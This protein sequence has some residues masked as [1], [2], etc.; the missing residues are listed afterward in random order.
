MAWFFLLNI[1]TLV[2]CIV[3]AV[4]TKSDIDLW[5]KYKGYVSKNQCY[6]RG[7]ICSCPGDEQTKYFGAYARRLRLTISLYSMDFALPSYSITFLRKIFYDLFTVSILVLCN[8][9]KISCTSYPWHSLQGFLI[10]F[11]SVES[12]LSSKISNLFFR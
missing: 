7:D 1:V 5:D 3:H 10:Y 8:Q 9:R 6:E 4:L 2:L 11:L 12:V